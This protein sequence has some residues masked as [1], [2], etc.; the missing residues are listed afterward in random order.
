[1]MRDWGLDLMVRYQSAFPITPSSG[2]AVIFPDGSYFRPRPDQ[3]PGQPLYINDPTVPGGR[4]FNR[5]AFTLPADGQQGNFPRNGLRG[6]PASQVDLALRRE[7]RLSEQ[8][9]LQLR[10]ELFNLFNHPNFG[11][12]ENNINSSLF[13]KP[14]NTLNRSLGGLNQL[15]QMGGPRSGQ[16]A[17]KIMF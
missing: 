17:V 3:V 16:L 8:V 7:F 15:Y 11:D 9:R 4:R 10:G 1:L 12:I 5:A 6:L 2:S 13:G 14:K